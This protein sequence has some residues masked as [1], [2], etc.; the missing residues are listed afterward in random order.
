MVPDQILRN[1]LRISLRS[2]ETKKKRRK[3]N[4]RREMRR[5]NIKKGEGIL[6]SEKALLG[7][8]A[9]EKEIR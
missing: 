5:K 3:K 2:T 1:F 4:E 8:E 7:K 9:M 6:K